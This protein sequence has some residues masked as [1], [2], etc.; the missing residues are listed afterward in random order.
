MFMFEPLLEFGKK[1]ELFGKPFDEDNWLPL[2][3]APFMIA[4]DN[5]F[6]DN[7]RAG[8]IGPMGPKWPFVFPTA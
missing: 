7:E 5:G 4:T 2:V 1:Y 3:V 6:G 8:E